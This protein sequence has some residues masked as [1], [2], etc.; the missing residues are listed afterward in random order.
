MRPCRRPHARVWGLACLL[1]LS[2]APTVFAQQ[3]QG[4]TFGADGLRLRRGDFRFQLGGYSQVDF[5]GF[6]DW[7]AGDED[8]GILRSDTVELRR[9]R[10][11]LEAEY[12]RVSFEVDV[13]PQD[14]GDELKDL[15][16][17][18]RLAK[19]LH[20]RGGHMKLPVS[21][22]FLTSAAR[23]D[24][25]ER[26]LLATHIGPARDWGVV[27]EG[28]WDR[29]AVQAGVFEGDGRTRDDRSRRTGVGRL[30]FQP[31]GGLEV[32]GSFSLAD[33]E[34]NP[35]GPGLDPE[36]K[37]ILGEGPSGF[38]FYERHF[39]NGRRRRLGLEAVVRQG[40]FR[41][42]GEWLQAREERLGQGSV[43]DDLPAQV[44]TGWAAAATW[45]VTGEK[46]TG[47]IKPRR[48]LFRGPGAIEIG[49]RLEELHFDDDGPGEGFEGAGNR[50]RNIRPAA[51]R[52]FT[53][54]LSWWPVEWIRLMGNVVV[55]RYDDPLLAP[56]PGRQ[57]NYVTFLA[58]TQLTLR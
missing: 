20:L 46:K 54:G 49:A 58:R 8:T 21:L 18:L 56:E 34:A 38:E 45:L 33:V 43:L 28:E 35:A 52:I 17:S 32:G 5:R 41:I 6:H 23:T 26:A 3:P 10:I 15:I 40:P 36:P 1:V 53:G 11:G 7:E 37:G 51:D 50:A 14:E 57:G 29:L 48:R 19:G 39:V 12:D 24:F 22:E 44:A 16:G 25:V 47:T 13:D 42:T 55:E 2:G 30:V 31:V 9:A 27:L 4:W